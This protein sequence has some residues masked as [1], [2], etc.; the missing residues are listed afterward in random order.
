[1][2]ATRWDVCGPWLRANKEL[3]TDGVIHQLDYP[4]GLFYGAIRDIAYEQGKL[5]VTTWWTAHGHI[6]WRGP[7]QDGPVKL[8]RATSANP[9]HC[10][11]EFDTEFASV[12]SVYENGTTSF[13]HGFA[14]VHLY[15]RSA[16]RAVRPEETKASWQDT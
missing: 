12:P 9:E 10:T 8:L 2:S 11:F 7:V 14:T 1:M 15:T 3:F 13:T 5:T 6:D 16:D 4:E